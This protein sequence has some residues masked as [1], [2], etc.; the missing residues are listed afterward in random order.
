MEKTYLLKSGG[1]GIN[2]QNGYISLINC[3]VTGNARNGIH[4]ENGT[5]HL[6]HCVLLQNDES[7]FFAGASAKSEAINTVMGS[8]SADSKISELVGCLI[9]TLPESVVIEDQKDCFLNM[10][11]G[12]V[13]ENGELTDILP[14]SRCISAGTVSTNGDYDIAGNF[15][16]QHPDI[17][18]LEYHHRMEIKSIDTLELT[19]MDADPQT[20]SDSLRLILDIE[21]P[22]GF[23]LMEGARYAISFG[24]HLVSSDQFDSSSKSDNEL[25]FSMDSGKSTLQMTL[26]SDQKRLKMSLNL[27][28]TQLYQDISQYVLNSKDN[29]SNSNV[30]TVYMP[31][32]G[33]AGNYQ[34]GEVW[35]NFDFEIKD[36]VS[37]GS[38]PRLNSSESPSD[39]DDDDATCFISTLLN[40]KKD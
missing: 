3:A 28:D 22:E 24:N 12:Y 16:D 9:E 27:S 7:D 31:I 6:E 33:V 17:G 26:S 37:E 14:D 29:A 32:Q 25:L 40:L 8:I 10:T 15:R 2:V 19:T 39:S 35:M 18:S 36:D 4:N 13:V 38:N 23:S 11:S 20:V 34:T 30:S 1:D 21:V 5:V